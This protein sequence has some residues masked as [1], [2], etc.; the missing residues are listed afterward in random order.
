MVEVDFGEFGFDVFGVALV[1]VLPDIFHVVDFGGVGG[2]ELVEE[3]L[4]EFGGGGAG[5]DAGDIHIWVAGAGEAEIDDTNHFVVLVEENVAEVKVAVDEFLFLGF[6]D[7]IM[8]GV[9]MVVVML[10][11]EFF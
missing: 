3:Y 5:D 1:D 2:F 10:V 11:I 8:V 6:F 7:V 4:L 9:D